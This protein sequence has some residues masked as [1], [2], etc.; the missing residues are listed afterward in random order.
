[1]HTCI[2]FGN[3]MISFW[4]FLEDFCRNYGISR[5]FSE[6]F[7]KI[8]PRAILSKYLLQIPKEILNRG[9]FLKLH[10]SITPEMSSRIPSG[11]YIG[12]SARSF[13]GRFL[14]EFLL[15]IILSFRSVYEFC[16]GNFFEKSSRSFSRIPTFDQR[17]SQRST[18]A[19]P[20]G[21]SSV[22][23][24]GKLPKEIFERFQKKLLMNPRIQGR[25]NG[26]VPERTPGGTLEGISRGILQE[27]ST[28]KK[29]RRN[30][31]GSTG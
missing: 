11:I 4:V 22:V 10:Q 28:K 24:S 2:L 8:S 3:S 31:S 21:T 12:N 20:E 26:G 9:F 17:V 29:T 14:L 6:D 23:F 7:L 5:D 27:L 16:S 19:F 18:E 13:N 30:L 1:M 25:L 15:E